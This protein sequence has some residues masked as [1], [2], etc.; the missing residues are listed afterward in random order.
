MVT[1]FFEE[2]RE[3]I[4]HIFRASL[5]ASTEQGLEVEDFADLSQTKGM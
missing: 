5:S 3:N 4:L 2:T 1:G